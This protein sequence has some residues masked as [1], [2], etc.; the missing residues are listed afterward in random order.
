MPAKLYQDRM[1]TVS[2]HFSRGVARSATRKCRIMMAEE[3]N[4]NKGVF[5][6]SAAIDVLEA[7]GIIMMQPMGMIL[8][9]DERLAPLVL[10]DIKPSI[11]EN[12]RNCVDVILEYHHIIDGANQVIARDGAPLNGLLWGKGRT[13][14]V[15]K[16][17][18]FF[19]PFGDR[20]KPKVMLE[21]GHQFG[22]NDNRMAAV[23]HD[24]RFPRAQ[25]QG[26]EISIPFPQMTYRWEAVVY[27]LFPA[28]L[29]NSLIA[30]TNI[31]PWM[32]M[33]ALT[34]LITEVSWEVND[35]S[36]IGVNPGPTYKM[37]F[38]FQYNSDT[39]DPLITFKDQETGNAPA[40]AVKADTADQFG[41]VRYQQILTLVNPEEP[42]GLG[43]LGEFANY[44]A[45]YWNVPALQ[46]IDFDATFQAMFEVAG[47]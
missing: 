33:P 34:W 45:G 29:A 23:N 32:G 31:S 17:T 18:N 24:P 22:V 7:R 43:G 35:P 30:R 12:D 40:A 39:Y 4:N 6:L 5:T 1:D 11:S 46:R 37:G 36:R 15:E 38:E 9:A 8:N 19:Y 26:G 3:T 47:P 10:T 28:R 41:V 2:A 27:T 42:I 16:A 21:V 25:I 13:S 20:T 14:I 44:P